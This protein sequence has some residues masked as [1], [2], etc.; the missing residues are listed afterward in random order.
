MSPSHVEA[1]RARSNGAGATRMS[2]RKGKDSTRHGHVIPRNTSGRMAARIVHHH[3]AGARSSD[4]QVGS[5]YGQYPYARVCF[6]WRFQ[7]G[8]S[9]LGDELRRSSKGG[10][11]GGG[12]GRCDRA[13]SAYATT[14]SGAAS[15][16]SHPQRQV[17]HINHDRNLALRLS[18]LLPPPPRRATPTRRRPRRPS[19]TSKSRT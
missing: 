2:A 1:H 8:S 10:G 17:Q 3:T 16:A 7:E 6:F 4:S 19:R 18:P 14:A 11:R 9:T 5:K 12:K 13:R 15:G